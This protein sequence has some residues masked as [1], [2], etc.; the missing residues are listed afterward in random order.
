MLTKPTRLVLVEPKWLCFVVQL[1]ESNCRHADHHSGAENAAVAQEDHQ[2]LSQHSQ[3]TL[4][5]GLL[6]CVGVLRRVLGDNCGL[7]GRRRHQLLLLLAL[8]FA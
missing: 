2:F 1:I 7:V 8:H 6:L 5:E 4:A 3:S